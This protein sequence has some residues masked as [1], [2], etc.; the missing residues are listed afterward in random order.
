MNKISLAVAAALA[1]VA[2]P[3]MAD[4]EAGFYAGV[5]AGVFGVEA[6]DDDVDAAL[7]DIFDED[8]TGFR[9]FGGWQFNQYFGIEAGYDSGAG[10]DKTLGDIT[11]DG[12]EADLDIDVSGFDVMLVG[13][14]PIGDTFYGFLKAGMLA[15]D[16]EAD[17]VIREDDGEGGVITTTLSGDDT[18]ED[19]A[20]GGGFGMNLGDNARVQVEYTVY[21]FTSGIEGDFLSGNFVWRFK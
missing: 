1:L 10:V 3:A 17:A 8:D 13:T 12:I 5:G 20:Y 11:T 4:D 2:A 14:L 9:V 16:V 19:P 21:D 18:G 15:W 6:D 7:N